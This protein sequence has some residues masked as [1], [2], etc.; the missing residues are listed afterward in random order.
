MQSG[1]TSEGKFKRPKIKG[2]RRSTTVSTT[3]TTETTTLASAFIPTPLPIGA[4]DLYDPCEISTSCGP[5]AKFTARGSEPIC[6]CPAGFSGIPRDGAPDPAHGCVRTP[7]RC[8]AVARE[9]V[10]ECPAGQS[11]V[12]DFCLPQCDRDSQCSLGERCV[13]GNCIKICF[14]DAHCLAG[15]FCQRG[16]DTGTAGGP[17]QRGNSRGQNGICVTGCRRDT[18]CPFG[19]ICISDP[20]NSLPGSMRCVDGC[21][22]NND[23]NLAT[24]CLRGKCDDPCGQFDECGTNAVCQVVSHSATCRCPE[25]YKELNSPYVACVPENMS[26]ERIACF[27]DTDCVSGQVCSEWQCVQGDLI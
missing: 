26:L 12:R 15:E 24:A 17:I 19:Q 21:H 18:N 3:T 4:S 22:F 10:N 9:S 11:C 2:S 23:C 8:S 7:E 14:Y 1:N 20:S 27:K 6:S 13:D 5:N 16:N 25:G